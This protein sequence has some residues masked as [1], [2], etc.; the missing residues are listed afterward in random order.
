MSATV[1]LQ[2]EG[3]AVSNPSEGKLKTLPWKDIVRLA[4]GAA[5]W[6]GAIFLPVD[7]RMRLLLFLAAYFTAGIDV[8]STVIGNLSRGEIFDE[9]FLMAVATG[10]AF[11]IG[12]YSEAVAVMLFYQTG[13]LVQDLA[14]ERSKGSILSLIDIRP[15]EATL[16]EEGGER[17]VRAEEVSVGQ[18]LLVKPGE[19]IPLDGEVAEGRSSLDTSSL[20]GESVPQDVAAGDDVLAGSVNLGGTLTVLV[21]RPYGDSTLSK[22]LRLIEEAR[23]RKAPTERFITSFAKKYTPAVVGAAALLAIAPP[24]LGMGPFREWGYRALV[25]LVVACPCA[26]V[27]SVPLALFGGIGAASRRG[28]LVKGGNVL[29][30]LAK[31]KGVLFDKTGTLTQGV[32]SLSSVVPAPGFEKTELLQ[33]AASAERGSNHPIARAV[34]EAAGD[35]SAPSGPLEELPGLGVRQIRN[36][37]VLLAGNAALLEREG[38]RADEAAERLPGAVVHVAWDGR[39]AG[40]LLVEDTVREESKEAVRRLRK[41]GVTTIGMLSGDRPENAGKVAEALGLDVW[42]AG[43]MPSDKLEHFKRIRKEVGAPILF[44]GD[45]M[46]DAPLLAAADAGIAMGGLGADAAIEAA[47]GVILNDDPLGVVAG[48]EIAHKTR[49]IVW[50]NIVFALGVKGVVLLLGAFG[51]ATMWEAVF[52]DVGVALL[53]TL[54]AARVLKTSS[55]LHI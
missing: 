43:L 44:V 54:N 45:G 50:Q 51:V 24:L 16:I 53:A 28:V 13:E 52:A 4:I 18:L 17:T 14:V 19:R 37:K 38:I 15:D 2:R 3:R 22:G 25:F 32:F 34:V 35:F 31:V 55:D 6:L 36:G 27:I 23:E 47:D 49:R 8:L 9:F 11:A 12:D 7:G 21:T 41:L 30:T 39:Y 46:N 5:L 10:G 40:F 33:L 20:T 1:P 42:E 26:L 29:E 48:I